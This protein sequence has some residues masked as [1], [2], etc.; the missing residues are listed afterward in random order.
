ME[1]CLEYRRIGTYQ[2]KYIRGKANWMGHTLRRSVFLKHV[3]D[4]K[5]E[6]KTEVTGR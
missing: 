3:I 2:I 6:G 4:G 1:Y 5:T